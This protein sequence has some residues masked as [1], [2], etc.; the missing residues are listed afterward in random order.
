[1]AFEA[2]DDG[3]SNILLTICSKHSVKS[4]RLSWCFQTPGGRHLARMLPVQRVLP[5]SWY[6]VGEDVLIT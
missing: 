3:G 1:M 2:G 4:A 6:D 5:R